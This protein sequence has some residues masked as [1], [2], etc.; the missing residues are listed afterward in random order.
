[1]EGKIS[2]GRN[3]T[4]NDEKLNI[5]TDYKVKFWKGKFFHKK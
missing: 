1:M 2:I 5:D 3:M 4:K